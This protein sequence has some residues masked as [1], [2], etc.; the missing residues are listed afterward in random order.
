MREWFRRRRELRALR[1]EVDAAYRRWM[2]AYREYQ[3]TAVVFR[4]ES[5]AWAGIGPIGKIQDR[6]TEHSDE[7]RRLSAELRRKQENAKIS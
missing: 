7:Y 4:D 2:R 6:V 5:G 3:D 1:R